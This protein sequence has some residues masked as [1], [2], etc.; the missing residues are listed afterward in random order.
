[1][2][3]EIKTHDGLTY[4]HLS[5]DIDLSCS[6][7]VRLLLIELV[8]EQPVTIVELS[9]VTVIDSSGIA[10]LL[11]AE[12]TAKR[13]GHKF[14]LASPSA[15]VVRVLELAHLDSYFTIRDHES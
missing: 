10:S 14:E 1:M 11:D 8:S 5:G 2:K 6:E 7:R 9:Q 4:I 13:R 15:R 3:H 12:K